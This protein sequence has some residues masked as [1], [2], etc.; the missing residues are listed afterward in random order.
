MIDSSKALISP[1]RLMILLI[2]L[3]FILAFH[4]PFLLTDYFGEADSARI[5]NDSIRAAYNHNIHTFGL[6]NAFLS[7]IQ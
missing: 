7:S 1:I 5:A 2:L 6:L 3:C 4:T